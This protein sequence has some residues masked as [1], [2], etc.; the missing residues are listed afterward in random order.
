[1]TLAA[2]WSAAKWAKKAAQHTEAGSL[3][4]AR[5]AQANED[6]LALSKE[7]SSADLRAW[8]TIDLKLEKAS[9]NA[10]GVYLQFAVKLENLGKSPA[11]L[12]GVSVHPYLVPS[13]TIGYGEKPDTT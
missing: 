2:A 11:H 4:A 1:L 12:V 5:A 9:R 10:K 7:I 3:Q 8:V 6:M 13:I